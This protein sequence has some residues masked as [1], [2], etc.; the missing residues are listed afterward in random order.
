M[1][2]LVS[3]FGSFLALWSGV[4]QAL[5]E[6]E[7]VDPRGSSRGM[8]ESL[9]DARTERAQPCGR[10]QT[11]ITTAIGSSDP[12]PRARS[13]GRVREGMAAVP[14]EG[15]AIDLTNWLHEFPEANAAVV[16]DI[17]DD[18]N[19]ASLARGCTLWFWTQDDTDIRDLRGDSYM[20]GEFLDHFGTRTGGGPTSMEGT[21]AAIIVGPVPD[22]RALAGDDVRFAVDDQV[23]TFEEPVVAY[24]TMGKKGCWGSVTVWTERP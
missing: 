4:A 13:S 8:I 23:F 16:I 3:S 14:V 22:G 12:P 24:N 15:F 7:C 10:P 21:R 1:R 6:S 17:V 11:E 2:G 19:D 18:N 20:V 5:V 9:P